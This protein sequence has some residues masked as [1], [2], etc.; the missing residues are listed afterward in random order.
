[1]YH[2]ADKRKRQ[3]ADHD[4]VSIINLINLYGLAVDTQR[5]DLF[6]RVFTQ[7]VD[8][9]FGESSHWR[10]LASFKADFAVFHDPFDSTQHIM[11]NHLVDVGGGIAHAFTYGSWH[12]L[13]KGVEGR[14]WWEGTGWYDDELVC[15]DGR[16]LIKRRTC[17]IVWWDGN[18]L[19]QET[20]PGV[21]FKLQSTVLRREA[22]AGRVG[23]LNA[24]CTK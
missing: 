16:W 21:K 6:D 11:M 4:I 3:M 1:L 15:R 24:V 8:A 19:V 14:S 12:L 2:L 13:R 20:I 7:D 18:P 17:R 5:W 23:Y 22:N 10:D 9:D